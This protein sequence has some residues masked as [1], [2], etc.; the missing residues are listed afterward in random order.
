MDLNQFKQIALGVC[1]AGI[2]L[3]AVSLVLPYVFS[4]E[5]AWSDNAAKEYAD[6]AAELYRLTH[7]HAGHNHDAS[8]AHE[9]VEPAELQEARRRWDEQRNRL[10]GAVG[11]RQWLRAGVKWAGI[12]LTAV[13]LIATFL[14]KQQED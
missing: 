4:D 12:L 1:G 3:I 7:V 2:L 8:H 10:N 13:G 6:A 11:G 9:S 5:G 14:I